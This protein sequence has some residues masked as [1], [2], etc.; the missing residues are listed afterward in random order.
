MS[1]L[2]ILVC[3]RATHTFKD[4]QTVEI[5][6]LSRAEAIQVRAMVR[7]EKYAEAE[8]F[9]IEKAVGIP[10]DVAANWH[11]ISPSEDVEGLVDAVS[12]LSGLREEEG[13]ADAGD[14]PSAKSTDSTTSS[15]R[16]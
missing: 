5:R 16:P 4:G 1:G 11:S 2:P 9:V 10:A 7:D 3:P 14:S 13:K 8:A 12:A 15:Q 6:G